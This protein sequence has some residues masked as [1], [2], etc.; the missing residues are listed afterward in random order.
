MVQQHY[1]DKYTSVEECNW[2]VGQAFECEVSM[3]TLTAEP[4]FLLVGDRVRAKVVALNKI[5][6]SRESQEG[7]QAII[8]SKPDAPTLVATQVINQ[9]KEI[10][11]VF[12]APVFDGEDQISEYR[13]YIRQQDSEDFHLVTDIVS[14]EATSIDV[15]AHS[16]KDAP[17]FI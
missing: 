14:Q 6:P 1:D 8:K 9:G 3:D 13:Y 7:G 4:F 11:I 16:L 2:T 12:N 5:G 17:F 15:N 10:R